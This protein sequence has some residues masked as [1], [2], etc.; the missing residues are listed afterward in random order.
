MAYDAFI[1][2][3]EIGYAK[4]AVCAGGVTLVLLVLQT[5]H[6][7]NLPDFTA[8]WA[9][10]GFI[11]L[12]CC[13]AYFT[14]SAASARVSAGGIVLTTIIVLEMILSGIANVYALDDDVVFS[15]RSSYRKFTDK[16]IEAVSE[17]EDDGFYRSEKLEH[18]K[19]NDN[20]ALGLNGLSNSTST[21]NEEVI[22]LLRRFGLTSKAH[23]SKYC[24][25]TVTEDVFFGLKYLYADT[26]KTQL[27]Y[28]VAFYYDMLKETESGVTIYEN[29]YALSPVFSSPDAMKDFEIEDKGCT[30]PFDL[31]NRLYAVLA[32]D[33]DAGTI[34]KKATVKNFEYDDLTKFGV[35][36]HDGYEKSGNDPTL[37]YTV[38][39]PQDGTLYMYI[40]SEYPRDCKLYVNG[41]SMGKY[42]TNDT[43]CIKEIGSVEE[44]EEV[45]IQLK[46][47]K[48]KTYFAYG[49]DYFYVFDDDAFEKAMNNMQ[50]NSLVT[51]SFKEDKIEGTLTVE[52]G[53]T[54]IMTTIPYDGG[55]KIT[56]NGERVVYEKAMNALIA[57][58]LP[59]G[60]YEIVLK[61][62]PTCFTAGAVI[63]ASGLLIFACFVVLEVLMK[64][65]KAEKPVK[66]RRTARATLPERKEAPDN[67]D[68][69]GSE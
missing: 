67:E 25:G 47:E 19:T 4:V 60:E 16:Y 29:P 21:L 5:L 59:A 6:L 64:K 22:T 2:I 56:A 28:H 33:E 13:V 30:D 45:K 46:C 65:K 40:P 58:D 18:R 20:F 3:K 35:K 9:S 27:P 7:E 69:E 26:E 68:E 8:I 57:F 44:G 15:T 17:L 52:E 36:D 55:W 12:Y 23:W 54:R 39:A 66:V 50:C 53:K 34:Y 38:T 10:L 61:Y 37:T 62:R 48:E 51:S 41:L 31:M 11:G 32:G 24:G 1:R 49:F 63:S 43:H 14:R 42:F